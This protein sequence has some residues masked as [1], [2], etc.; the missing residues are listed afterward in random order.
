MD[1]A[2]ILDESVSRILAANVQLAP[3]PSLPT[4]ETGMRHRAAERMARQ[5]SKFVLTISRRRGGITLY[6]KDPKHQIND[7]N[8]LIARINQTISTVDRYK[9]NLD[10]KAS[11]IEADELLDQVP[12][13]QITEFLLHSVGI[14]SLLEEM[15]P[16]VVE[17]G[18]EGRLLAM[19]LNSVGEEVCAVLRLFIK[20]Y[21]T[22]KCANRNV[23]GIID[24]LKRVEPSDHL[25]V[26]HLL[27]WT[28][29]GETDMHDLT[30]TP[31]GYRLLQQAAKIPDAAADNVID[32]FKD[33][34][35]LIRA[36]EVSLMQVEGIGAKRAKSIIEGIQVMRNRGLYR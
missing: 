13:V 18:N 20:D 12:L 7:I 17:I 36:D 19:R 2:I 35:R 3:D 25:K 10:K 14:M 5:T 9:E 16:Y 34:V 8:Y 28:S 23:S 21:C 33:L 11:R 26:A 1:G 4:N 29:A 32:R 22:L 30:V 24:E 31:R 27:G 15:A 6:Y